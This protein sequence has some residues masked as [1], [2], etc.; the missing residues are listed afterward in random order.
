M[1]IRNAGRWAPRGASSWAY[2]VI[3][4]AVASAVRWL[5]HPLVGPIM[6]GTAFCIAA[7]LIEYWFGIVPAFMVMALGL[8]I[9]D[10]LFVPPYGQVSVL[11]QSDLALIISYPVVT[12]LVICLIER[13]RRA[14]FR[15]ELLGQVSQSRYEMLLRLDNE[16]A[17]ASRGNDETHR[18][19]RHL[20]HYHHDIVLIKA[21]DRKHGAATV[22][23]QA[24]PDTPTAI[25]PGFLY[26]K[27]AAEDARRLGAISHA[28][29]YRVHLAAAGGVEKA[30]DCVC[31]RFNTHVGDFIVCRVGEP[32]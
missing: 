8:G 16:R 3:A 22:I 18:L 30:V 14:Q 26:E 19:L 7:A 4:L 6:P 24:D 25:A 12:I 20:P 5:I 31:E 29:T 23:N 28:G 21:L 17:I 9:A 11:D 15:A 10:Y 27:V 2:S 1:I 32:V 13:L